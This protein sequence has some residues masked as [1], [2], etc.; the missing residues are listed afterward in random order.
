MSF[1]PGTD[2]EAGDAFACDAIEN[3]IIPRSSDIGGF[4]VRGHCRHASDAS[5]GR[6]S[7]STAWAPR[8]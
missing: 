6:S 8:S 2:P 4:E 5:S 1:F 7:S 3:L